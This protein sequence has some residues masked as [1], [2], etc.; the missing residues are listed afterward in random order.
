MDKIYM[1]YDFIGIYHLDVKKAR[2]RA[3]KKN[4]HFCSG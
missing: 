2:N 4:L 3:L 1:N